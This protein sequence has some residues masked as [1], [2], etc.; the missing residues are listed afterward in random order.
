MTPVVIAEAARLLAEARRSGP[1]LEAFPASCRPLSLDVAHAI[2][3]AT[4]E[5]IGDSIGGWKVGATP[6]G[7]LARGALLRSRLV[8]GGSRVEASTLP[9]LGVECEIA[10][11]FDRDL[12]PRSPAYTY[13]EVADAVTALPGIEIVDSRFVGYPKAPLLD[14]VA[15]CMSNGAFIL[16]TPRADWREFDLADLDAE[17]AIGGRTIVRRTGGHPAQDPLLP[18]VA[19]VNDLRSSVGVRAGEIVTTGT[20]TGLNFALPGQRV[21]AIFH[22]FGTAEVTFD[23]ATPR[24]A[25]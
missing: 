19:L 8:P 22:G 15:D 4:A 10:F 5:C 9:L 2:Q 1:T 12:G 6:E 17:L 11:R 3:L 16:G 21:V 13:E 25:R 7:R 20:Y 14:R 24:G 18:A 23:D